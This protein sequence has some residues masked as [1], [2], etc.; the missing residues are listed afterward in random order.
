[1]KVNNNTK[2]GFF[3]PS[4]VFYTINGINKRVFYNKKGVLLWI[5][6]TRVLKV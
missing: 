3:K 4:F 6:F 5:E 1:M 2:L